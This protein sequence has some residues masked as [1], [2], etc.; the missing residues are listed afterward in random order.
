MINNTELKE[1][2]AIERQRERV[3][4]CV[5]IKTPERTENSQA[6]ECIPALAAG[7]GS[8]VIRS[9][10]KYFSTKRNNQIHMMYNVPQTM[11]IKTHLGAEKSL[12]H[13][14]RS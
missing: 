7:A 10:K 14:H 13:A 9:C 11:L 2:H 6:R 4:V 12:M 8:E 5:K 3:C 1:A